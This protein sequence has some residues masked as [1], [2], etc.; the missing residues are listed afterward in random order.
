MYHRFNFAKHNLI[1][2]GF[3]PLKT[4]KEI[5]DERGFLRIWDCGSRTWV[6]NI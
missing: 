6:L 1:K 5:M 3:D 4:E 2:C